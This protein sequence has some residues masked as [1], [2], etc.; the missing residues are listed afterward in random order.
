MTDPW[1][2]VG[3][4]VVVVL[5]GAL[6]YLA[7]DMRR[8]RRR[9]RAYEAAGVDH[10]DLYVEEH[11]PAILRNFDLVTKRRFKDWAAEVDS[12]LGRV[13]KDLGLVDGFRE[14]LDPRLGDVERRLD[15]LEKS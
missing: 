10:M 6:L 5:L 1:T 8:E 9:R 14:R 11:F 7:L 12:R 3:T 15:R 13:E 2:V 4:V